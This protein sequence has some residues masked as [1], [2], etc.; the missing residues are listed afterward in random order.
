M[1]ALGQSET[2]IRALGQSETIT[3]LDIANSIYDILALLFLL[4]P[5]HCGCCVVGSNL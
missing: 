1:R 5:I 4:L 3:I 2:I